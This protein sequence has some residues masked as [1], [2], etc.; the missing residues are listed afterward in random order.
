M[1]TEKMEKVAILKMVVVAS[2][3]LAV[4]VGASSAQVGNPGFTMD[5]TPIEGEICP[6]GIATYNVSAVSIAQETEYVN[7]TI[8]P[9][10]TGWTYAFTPVGFDLPAGETRYSI[11][12]I[13]APTDAAP[14]DY[15]HDVNGYAWIDGIPFPVENA[16]HSNLKTT[17]TPGIPTYAN[18]GR[19]APNVTHIWETP[20]DTPGDGYTN[21]YPIPGENVTV[22]K[23]VVVDDKDGAGDIKEVF[24]RTFYPLGDGSACNCTCNESNRCEPGDCVL[25][26]ESS[27]TALENRTAC[28]EAVEAAYVDGLLKEDDKA[29]IKEFLDKGTG[30]IYIE[31]TNFNCS[32]PAGN[33]TVCAQAFDSEKYDCMA[34][35][36]K[37]ESI[38]SLAIDF[39]E[40]E[41]GNVTR[42]KTTWVTPGNVT[43]DG[44]DPMDIEIAAW[45]MTS[46]GGGV[47]PADKLDAK[48][49]GL[50]Q[51]LALPPGVLFEVSLQGYVPT[52]IE[53]SLHVPIDIPYGD[54]T[55]CIRMT[56]KHIG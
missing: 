29:D 31:H 26:E 38:I 46:T 50:E 21:V 9:E 47:I 3:V 2:M 36:F 24:V 12:S 43:N 23:Y 15:Y 7:F 6:G 44:N 40:V 14:E 1:K 25:K 18:V 27:A 19:D 35:T 51:W 49:N 55:G 28:D 11:L 42:N 5:V 22:N 33:Y 56:G 52:P 16:T 48:L 20:D 37:Y 13:G 39:S 34:N 54:Y 4:L 8:E 10:Q 45:N 17:V 41:Y 53:F 32:D 30:W